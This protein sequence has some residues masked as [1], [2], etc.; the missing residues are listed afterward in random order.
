MVFKGEPSM[1]KVPAR[2]NDA[3]S[4]SEHGDGNI[5]SGANTV[6][7]EGQA[8]AC[9][10]DSVTFADETSG[11][12]QQGNACVMIN[13]KR[14]ALVGDQTTEAGTLQQGASSIKIDEGDPFVF[15]GGNVK[16]GKNVVIKCK[17][18]PAFN[19]HFELFDQA[20]NQPVSSLNYALKTAGNVTPGSVNDAGK[21]NLVSSHQSETVELYAHLQTEILIE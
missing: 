3:V 7:F 16:F 6:T 12:I 9:E 21:T 8:A 4:N 18:K 2:F 11:A 15:I 1:S 10:G 5:T 17:P 14:V 19:Q 13:G 20:T